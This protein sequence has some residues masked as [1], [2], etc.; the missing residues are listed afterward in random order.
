VERDPLQE[1]FR[2]ELEET[3]RGAPLGRWMMEHRA[4]LARLLRGREPDWDRLAADF[5]AAGLTDGTGRR[6]TGEGVRLT[7]ASV[8]AAARQR[9]VMRRVRNHP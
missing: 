8:K 5:A 1:R 7:W 2:A 4:E 9:V 3:W 6:P